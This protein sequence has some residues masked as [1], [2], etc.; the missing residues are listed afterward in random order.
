MPTCHVLLLQNVM[1]K[2]CAN[3]SNSFSHFL[4]LLLLTMYRCCRKNAIMVLYSK[5]IVLPREKKSWK[6]NVC[7]FNDTFVPSYRIRR[8]LSIKKSREWESVCMKRYGLSHESY[9]CITLFELQWHI[10][11]LLI[12]SQTLLRHSNSQNFITTINDSLNLIN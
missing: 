4:L 12:I 1:R 3:V 6:E 10:Q 9:K 8:D 7:S 5:I 11:Q 2:I